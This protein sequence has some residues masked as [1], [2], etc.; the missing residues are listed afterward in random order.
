VDYSGNEGMPKID[1][2]AVDQLPSEVER[3]A[4]WVRS[5][6]SSLGEQGASDWPEDERRRLLPGC[7]FMT[8]LVEEEL[9]EAQRDFAALRELVTTDPHAIF[10]RDREHS[11]YRHVS[12]V[13]SQQAHWRRQI[14]ATLRGYLHEVVD[15]ARELG[16][17]D[18]ELPVLLAD[19][20]AP[21]S[22]EPCA[23][24]VA[25]AAARIRRDRDRRRPTGPMR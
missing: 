11:R 12:Q 2:Y 1:R 14:C 13:E 5:M 8:D 24:V 9:E 25:L 3:T 17:P 23:D 22:I 18:D 15:I 21:Q 16:V 19:A 4:S 20:V 6:A 7:R 10:A